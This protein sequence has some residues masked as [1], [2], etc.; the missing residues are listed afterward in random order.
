VTYGYDLGIFSWSNGESWSG[1]PQQWQ[2][3]IAPQGA[4]TVQS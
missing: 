1:T 2:Q 4:N 3:R